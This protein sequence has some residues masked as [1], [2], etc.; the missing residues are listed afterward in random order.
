MKTGF[1]LPQI[2]QEN[3]PQ[4]VAQVAQAAEAQGYDSLWVLERQLLPAAVQIDAYGG[5]S[6]G[7][8]P[9]VYRSVLDPLETLAYVAAMTRRVRLGTSVLV[10]PFHGAVILARQIATLDLLSGGRAIC[11][12]GTGWSRV[13]YAANDAPYEARGARLGELIAAIRAIWSQEVVEFHGRFYHIEPCYIGPKPLQKPYPPLYLAGYADSALRRVARLADSWHPA[14]IR[15]WPWLEELIGKLRHFAG[16]AGRKPGE[17]SL[18]LHAFVYMQERS[19]GA[20]RLPFVG[21][22][23]QIKDDVQRLAALGFDEIVFDVQFSQ[24]MTL[25]RMLTELDLLRVT[26]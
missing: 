9:E 19:A 5:A 24:G 21:D 15:S 3:G 26:V 16:E 17:P 20:D 18:S 8:L 22:Y 11:G 13:E 12:L 25:A 7:V 2:G 1:A 10:A 4:A 23:A 14:R 6:D